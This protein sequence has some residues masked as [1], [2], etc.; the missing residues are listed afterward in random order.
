MSAGLSKRTANGVCL[1]P[2][3]CLSFP[4][5]GFDQAVLSQNLRWFRSTSRPKSANQALTG[6]SCYL[7]C[8][9]YP[10]HSETWLCPTPS[11]HQ[12]Q[13]GTSHREISAQHP[14]SQASILNYLLLLQKTFQDHPGPGPLGPLSSHSSDCE[15]DWRPS[16]SR[17]P[18]NICVKRGMCPFIEPLPESFKQQ[19]VQST[20]C[21]SGTVPGNTVGLGGDGDIGYSGTQSPPGEACQESDSGRERDHCCDR[22]KRGALA[23][24][25]R[26][27]AWTVG[28][29]RLLCKM[30]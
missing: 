9:P 16:S 5:P 8:L 4:K 14:G 24:T 18:R 25:V 19:A 28:V 30:N 3:I 7:P 13:G 23:S 11:H 22:S 15:K 17:L 20:Y 6:R 21:M 2:S 27:R 12:I 10:D 29:C 26:H 1:L